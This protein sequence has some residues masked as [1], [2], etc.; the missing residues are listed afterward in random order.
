MSNNIEVLD[1]NPVIIT[2]SDE[3]LQ[4][5]NISRIGH[6]QNGYYFG[7]MSHNTIWQNSMSK[8]DY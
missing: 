5:V 2:L 6:L 7:P 8:V 3:A 1:I 4:S